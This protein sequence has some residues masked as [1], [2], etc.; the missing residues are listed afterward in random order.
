M[1]RTLILIPKM[2]SREEFKK[3]TG[4]IPEDF[5]DVSKE[6]WDY[7]KQKLKPLVQKVKKVYYEESL[8]KVEKRLK[9]KS[10]YSIIKMLL[11]NNGSLIC[12]DSSLVAETEAWLEMLNKQRDNGAI[13]LYEETVKERKEY[14]AKKIN[15]T[16]KEGEIGVF[17]TNLNS[18][19]PFSEDIRIIKMCRFDP[20]DYLKRWQKKLE[21]AH[22]D[23]I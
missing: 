11:E 18:N 19:M 8:M 14:I 16:L 13:E 15:Q 4:V 2:F 12:E 22:A 17:L 20:T 6:F 7:V 23:P 9:Q 10:E 21:L 5:N 3:L 1:V